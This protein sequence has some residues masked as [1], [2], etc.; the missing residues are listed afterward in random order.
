MWNENAEYIR[1]LK[2]PV[3]PTEIFSNTIFHH[4]MNLMKKDTFSQLLD[5]RP[6]LLISL[7]VTCPGLR[8]SHC[9][10]VLP[11]RPIATTFQLASLH[12]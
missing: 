3:L 8:P 4:L 11:E 5:C 6:G 2:N 10:I 12:Q 9:E 1:R 7:V